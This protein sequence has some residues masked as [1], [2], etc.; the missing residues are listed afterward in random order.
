[1]ELLKQTDNFDCGIC[2][3]I[4]LLK[5]YKINHINK[6]DLYNNTYITPD[7][8]SIMELELLAYK[9]GIFLDSYQASFNEIINDN[10]LKNPFILVTNENGNLHYIVGVKEKKNIT[11]YDPKGLVKKVS[12]DSPLENYTDIL[13]K[14]EKLNDDFKFEKFLKEKKFNFI[15]KKF[16]ILNILISLFL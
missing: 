13:I 10:S 5:H 4:M 15:N 2:S 7:G 9:F 12:L 6:D 11:I 16:L 8:I 14:S 1:M 3:L